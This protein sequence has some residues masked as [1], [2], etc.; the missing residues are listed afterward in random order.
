MLLP[1]ITW[2]S[3]FYRCINQLLIMRF[4]DVGYIFGGTVAH[5]HCVLIKY[6]AKLVGGWEVVM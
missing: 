6:F 5:L 4:D 3:I 1:A 2:Q